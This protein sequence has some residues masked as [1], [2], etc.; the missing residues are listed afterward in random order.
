MVLN[1]NPA[2]SD[3]CNAI[4]LHFKKLDEA[5]Y[6]QEYGSNGQYGAKEVEKEATRGVECHGLGVWGNIANLKILLEICEHLYD[7]FHQPRFIDIEATFLPRHN[8]SPC[9]FSSH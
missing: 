2:S 3:V 4:H 1:Q 5:G 8:V 7:L 6:Q 9:L